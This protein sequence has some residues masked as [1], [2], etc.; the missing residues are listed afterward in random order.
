VTIIYFDTEAAT[1]VPLTAVAQRQLLHQAIDSLRDHSGQ[2]FMAKGMAC[3]QQQLCDLPKETAKR[4]VLLTDGAT[5][6]EGQC[7]RL[8]GEFAEANTPII[9]IGI[10]PEYKEKLMLELAQV[11]QGRPYHLENM[12]QLRDILDCEVG[13]SVR[14]VITDL[15]AKVAH[16][17][18]VNISSC[19]R[20]FPSLSDVSSE[21]QPFR[22]GNIAAGDY[23][24]FI[25]EFTIEGLARPASRVRIAQVSLAGS[26]PGL[27]KREEFAPQDLFVTFTTD[28]AAVAAVDPVV[29]GY[30]Q[31]K[32]VDNLIQKAMGQATVNAG[33]ARQ[34]LQVAL[35]MTQRI[36]NAAMTKVLNNALDELNKSGTIS[37]GTRKTVALGGR[38][39]TVKSGSAVP[40]EG[41]PSEEEIRKVTGV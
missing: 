11:S 37:A 5:Q 14:E 22:L 13:S 20:V 12:G 23:T 30:V 17:K 24:V 8:A 35:G 41:M 34:T 18:G 7:R 28:E 4:V 29:L 16:V 2:T 19:T 6:Q 15:Q 31:Q 32:N 9:A 10:G 38:T 25:L 36:G 40:L 26:V 1:L 33:Q 27:G 39:K 3:A 21:A